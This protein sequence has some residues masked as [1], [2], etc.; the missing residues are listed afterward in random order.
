MNSVCWHTCLLSAGAGVNLED[1]PQ[2]L[3]S[4]YNLPLEVT[5]F[6]VHICGFESYASNFS[7]LDS[8]HSYEL[9]KSFEEYG[10]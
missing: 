4:F 6:T 9:E 5:Q 10:F 3:I 1:R 7:S 2:L 8:L